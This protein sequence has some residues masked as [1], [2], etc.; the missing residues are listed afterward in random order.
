MT[1]ENSGLE[2]QTAE[3]HISANPGSIGIQTTLAGNTTAP[4]ATPAATPLGTSHSVHNP[5][6]QV[7]L[8]TATLRKIKNV[9]DQLGRLMLLEDTPEGD[10]QTSLLI[11]KKL[12]LESLVTSLKAKEVSESSSC[13]FTDKKHGVIPVEAYPSFNPLDWKSEVAQGRVNVGLKGS[14]IPCTSFLD[15]VSRFEVVFLNTSDSL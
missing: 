10:A 9:D 14:I 13:H 11:D 6:N 12:K 5:E 1:T 7:D 3:L 2:Q 4:I 8:L 15:F